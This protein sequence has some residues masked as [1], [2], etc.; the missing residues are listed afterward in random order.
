MELGREF[1]NYYVKH[2][3]KNIRSAK[4]LFTKH[5]FTP[6][7]LQQLDK[8]MGDTFLLP[9]AI[10]DDEFVALE[11]DLEELGISPNEESEE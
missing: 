10:N 2:L 3:G 5:V 6:E 4:E 1:Q 8:K 9:E 7:V 11:E